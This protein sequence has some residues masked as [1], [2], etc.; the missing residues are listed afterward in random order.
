MHSQEVAKR[1]W[2]FSFSVVQ[3][4][5]GASRLESRNQSSSILCRCIRRKWQSE[6]GSSP[7]QWSKDPGGRAGWKAEIKAARFF[8]D[9]FAGSGKANMAV[10]LFS[11]PRTR[12]GEPAG[13][14]KSKQLDSLSMHSQ[15][16]AKRTWQ[17][18]FSVVQGPG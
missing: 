13:K 4:P 10:L 2:Q 3:G 17:F 14:Q 15:E 8:V 16:V 7:F 5:G 9:A 18:S 1:T 11:G 6:H 12:G